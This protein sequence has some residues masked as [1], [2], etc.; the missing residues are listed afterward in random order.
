[1]KWF[2]QLAIALGNLD[3]GIEVI[4]E[5]DIEG[6]GWVDLII[7]HGRVTETGRGDEPRDEED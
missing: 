3:P 6:D 2:E 7:V 1:M 5:C 4:V